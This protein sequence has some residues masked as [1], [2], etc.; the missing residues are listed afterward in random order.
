MPAIF[1]DNFVKASP[2]CAR[3]VLE[4]VDALRKAGHNCVEFDF[5]G[6]TIQ[7]ILIYTSDNV[8]TAG[9]AGNIFVGLTSADG[10]KTMLGH[11]GPDKK[12]EIVTPKS[13]VICLIEIVWHRR[14]HYSWLPLVPGY[15]VS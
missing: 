7:S 4:T 8:L 13:I 3:A 14:I 15:L 1:T 12:V 5:P 10:Y 11:L 2:A 9:T 6:G